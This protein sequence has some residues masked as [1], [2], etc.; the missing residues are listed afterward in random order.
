MF[1]H[2]CLA[3]ASIAN[4]AAAGDTT[5]IFWQFSFHQYDGQG[6]SIKEEK[7]SETASVGQS[8]KQLR[9]FVVYS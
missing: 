4:S 3:A 8:G 5:R 7:V 6:K 1:K 9:T 2:F